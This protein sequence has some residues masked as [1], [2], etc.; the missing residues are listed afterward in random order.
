MQ[1]HLTSEV[2]WARPGDLSFEYFYMCFCACPF[3]CSTWALLYLVWKKFTEFPVLPV[4]ASCDTPA[5]KPRAG[6]SHRIPCL[7][8]S[9]CVMS[10]SSEC[11][12]F[13]PGLHLQVYGEP[14]FS[15]Q[16][17]ELWVAALQLLVRDTFTQVDTLDQWL[18]FISCITSSG[19]NLRENLCNHMFSNRETIENTLFFFHCKAR[20]VLFKK[21]D[22]F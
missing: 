21:F 17:W 13:P 6:Q 10:Q 16:S 7:S 5:D 14:H 8:M 18:R 3:V 9:M 2:P 22:P 15:V 12:L 19:P 11:S 1:L 4:K 20:S